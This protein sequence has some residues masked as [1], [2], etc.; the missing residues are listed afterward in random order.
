[1]KTKYGVANAWLHGASGPRQDQ[2]LLH[3][4]CYMLHV[5]CWMS[6]VTCCMLPVACCACGKTKTRQSQNRPTTPKPALA[7]PRPPA[8]PPPPLI[9]CATIGA[10]H[11]I[12]VVVITCGRCRMCEPRSCGRCRT[13]DH[14]YARSLPCSLPYVR[15]L[16]YT[17]SVD[18]PYK[19]RL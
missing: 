17:W 3:V 18:V 14:Q 19:G 12:R 15:S 16:P 11:S 2:S 9:P 6:H 1:M 7:P 4:A 8:Q 5:I 10:C 13:C